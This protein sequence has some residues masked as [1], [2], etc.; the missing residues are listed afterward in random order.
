MI[1]NDI[2]DNKYVNKYDIV[3]CINFS[4]QKLYLSQC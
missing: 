4:E 1:N 2:I 3:S